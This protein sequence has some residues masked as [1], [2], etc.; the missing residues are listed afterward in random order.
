MAESKGIVFNPPP[1][2]AYQK[3]YR[4]LDNLQDPR[5]LRQPIEENIKEINK[6]HYKK[7]QKREL[8]GLFVNLAGLLNVD[9]R[10]APSEDVV[11]QKMVNQLFDEVVALQQSFQ[12][13]DPRELSMKLR[14]I[15]G[16]LQLLVSKMNPNHNI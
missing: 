6:H 8:R 11:T 16:E 15:K 7:D 13:L 9:I 12:T 2:E 4:F 1:Q 14:N 5:A 3:V 10:K